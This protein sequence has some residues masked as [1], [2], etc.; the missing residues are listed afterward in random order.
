MSWPVE[1][2]TTTSHHP[3]HVWVCVL[4]YLPPYVLLLLPNAMTSYVVVAVLG[5]STQGGGGKS[6]CGDGGNC[7]FSA[8]RLRSFSWRNP[9]ELD[10]FM[11]SPRPTP[12]NSAPTMICV[13]SLVCPFSFFCIII[14]WLLIHGVSGCIFCA[15]CSTFLLAVLQLLDF[16]TDLKFHKVYA[17]L[18]R[19]M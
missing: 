5:S 19:V 9:L 4:Y 14:I 3:F 15:F 12:A 8:L 17:D 1:E 18:H 11:A 13:I 2:G 16:V 10:S 7:C 6:A